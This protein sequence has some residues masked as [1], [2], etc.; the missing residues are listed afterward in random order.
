MSAL[1]RVGVFA[2]PAVVYFAVRPLTDSDAVALAIAGAVPLVYQM[3]V[4]LVHRRIDGWAAVSG[5]GFVLACVVSAFA[6]GSSLP[7]K[8][9][10]AG[11]TFMLGLVLLVAALIRRPIPLQRLLKAPTNDAALGAF[12]G[13]FLVLHALLHLV[14]AIVLPTSTYVVAGRLV[15]WGTL[16]AGATLL[17]ACLRRL[18]ATAAGAAS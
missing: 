9:H 2:V 6:G 3:I 12:I 11:I 14:L 8:L 13:V 4:L 18:R 16:A 5:I 15:N 10:E 7:L 1:R 17:W